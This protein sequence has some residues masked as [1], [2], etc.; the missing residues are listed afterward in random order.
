[1]KTKAK[2]RRP[3]FKAGDVIQRHI[4]SA[5][6]YRVLEVGVPAGNI[7]DGDALCYLVQNEARPIPPFKLM[8]E[9]ADKH[10]QRTQD[11]VAQALCS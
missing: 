9:M 1:M 2:G 11:M 3:R 4:R 7:F 10:F 5:Y 6:C 8:I